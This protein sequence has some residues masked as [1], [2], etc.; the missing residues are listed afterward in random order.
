MPRMDVRS[1]RPKSIDLSQ[2]RGF[3]VVFDCFCKVLLII[4]LF[5]VFIGLSDKN[6]K[7]LML[8]TERY[9]GVLTYLCKTK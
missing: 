6:L 4:L 7:V 8:L 3:M 2:M 1:G 9:I 5:A